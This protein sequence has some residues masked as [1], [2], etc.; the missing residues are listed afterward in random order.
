MLKEKEDVSADVFTAHGGLF[1][2]KGVAQQLLANTLNVP[3]SVSESAGEGG[4]WGMALLAAYSLKGNSLPL[5]EWLDK[6]VFKNVETFI[7][8]PE[9]DKS[10]GFDKFFSL[11]KSGLPALNIL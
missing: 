3:V 6:E 4:A 9:A 2:V 8:Q 5:G 10:N 7:L 1:K 11:Y